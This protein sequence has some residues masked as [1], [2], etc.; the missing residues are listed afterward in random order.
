MIPDFVKPIWYLFKS[1]L[2]QFFFKNMIQG[3]FILNR[4][5]THVDPI[6]RMCLVIYVQS[7]QSCPVFIMFG[8]IQYLILHQAIGLILN[9]FAAHCKSVDIDMWFFY[10]AI[11]LTNN[12]SFMDIFMRS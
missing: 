6:P 10:L 9:C 5:E 8:K 12:D 11:C 3:S 4:I 2:N 1:E 7:E